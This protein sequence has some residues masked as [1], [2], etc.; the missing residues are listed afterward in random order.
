MC[1]YFF[2]VVGCKDFDVYVSECLILVSYLDYCMYY[3]DW[4]KKYCV[5]FFGWC[6]KYE[7]FVE[8]NYFICFK[9]SCFFWCW[10]CGFG[11]CYFELD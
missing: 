1:I 3:Y 8:F 6:C 10:C 7:I 11:G 9:V 2:W 4:I 5:K